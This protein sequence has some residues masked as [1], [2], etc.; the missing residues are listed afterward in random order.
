MA[1]EIGFPK[2]SIQR[3]ATALSMFFVITYLICIASG[4]VLPDWKLHEP[5]LQF[6][7]GFE[8]LTLQGVLI[9]LIESI[10]YAWYVAVLFGW[11]FNVFV[12]KQ[13]G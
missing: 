2:I 13:T 10:A 12:A 6:F 5:W 9:G 4:L 1:N 7:P 8:W 3:F 11:L